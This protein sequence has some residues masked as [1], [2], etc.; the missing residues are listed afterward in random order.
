MPVAGE[1][2][3]AAAIKSPREHGK[4][5]WLCRGG[6]GDLDLKTIISCLGWQEIDDQQ[7]GR[8][9]L[10]LFETECRLVTARYQMLILFQLMGPFMLL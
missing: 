9:H 3:P 5:S 6:N 10:C 8:L 2:G 7:S 4:G 1:L